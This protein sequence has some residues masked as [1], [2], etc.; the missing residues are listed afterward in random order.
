MNLQELKNIQTIK[1]FFQNGFCIRIPDFNSGFSWDI[2]QCTQFLNEIKKSTGESY[3]LGQFLFEK[4]NEI[5]F[6][7]DGQ[8]RLTSLILLL[9]AI[10]K[11][12]MPRGLSCTDQIREI[13]L[14][15]VFKTRAVD[16]LIFK[17]ITQNYLISSKN[18][19]LTISQKKIIDAFNFFEIELNKLE[20]SDIFL[21]EETI[22][23]A[24]LS[25]FYIT[26]TEALQVL[27]YLSNRKTQLGG[28]NNI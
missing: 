5:L 11:I 17:E 6:V 10:T 23:K 4:E 14:T 16:Q 27:S 22:E 15:D 26:R 13:Y 21:I 19:P 8:Q 12:K 9:S 25:S 2:P 3:N 28:L 1:S 20:S 24:V 18:I 7:I